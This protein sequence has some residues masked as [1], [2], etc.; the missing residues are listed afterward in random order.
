MTNKII[1]IKKNASIHPFHA[2]WKF[3][4]GSGHAPLAL[5]TD[6]VKM[7]KRVHDELGIQYVRFHGIFNDDM[8]VFNTLS[9]IFPGEG[10]RRFKEINFHKIGIAYDNILECGMKPFVELSFMPE[11]LASGKQQCMFYYKGNITPPADYEEWASFIREFIRYLIHRYGIEEIRNWYF[12]V[13]NEP[14]LPIFFWGTKE[15][16]YKLYEITA[17]AIKEVDSMLKVGGP[18]T[19]ASKWVGSFLEYCR[20]RYVPVDFVSTHQYAGDPIG[21]IEGPADLEEEYP[22]E[23]SSGQNDRYIIDYNSSDGTILEGIRILMP[24]KSELQDIPGDG[25]RTNAEIVRQQ[26]GTLPVIYTEW[27]ENAIFSAESNDTRKVAAYDL[28]AVLDTENLIDLSS[29]WCFSDLFEEFHHFPEEFHGGFGLLT[30]NG[31]PKPV[32]HMFRMLSCVSENRIDLDMN[33]QC[34]TC[35]GAFRD[36]NSMQIFLFRQ[37]MKNLDLSPERIWLEIETEL[38]PKQITVEKIDEDHGNPYRIWK[39]MGKPKDLN[40]DQIK[41]ICKKSAVIK[42]KISWEFVDET[43]KIPAELKV[44]DIWFIQIKW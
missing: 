13:W 37:N 44:N 16:Y 21:G 34:E 3:C 19:A 11:A 33:T 8:Q 26:A 17:R 31:I 23:E 39:E 36:E 40:K 38:N 28:K 30:S 27:N 4:V 14:D 20:N 42:E 32:Y 10:N 35:I 2:H 5:R 41:E 12:E 15:Q 9:D 25:F 24:D 29:I 6:Y 7:L 22:R 18:A 43:V 1:K